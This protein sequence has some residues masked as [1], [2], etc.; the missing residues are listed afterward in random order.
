MAE[1]TSKKKSYPEQAVNVEGDSEEALEI[2]E[3][4]LKLLDELHDMHR[5]IMF[6]LFDLTAAGVNEA[7]STSDVKHMRRLKDEIGFHCRMILLNMFRDMG[8]AKL[9]VGDF[10]DEYGVYVN[11]DIVISESNGDSIGYSFGEALGRHYLGQRDSLV[12]GIM[13]FAEYAFG[14]TSES[15]RTE[16][17]GVIEIK[18]V[19]SAR[20]LY[21]AS[22]AKAIIEDQIRSFLIKLEAN[23]VVNK[24][25]NLNPMVRLNHV[26]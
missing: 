6:K 8:E 24:D 20:A 15:I 2:E 14:G 7:P 9:I 4:L 25:G 12:K 19:L 17:D 1:R 18:S 10:D 5:V 21:F 23:Y 16:E 13:E 26:G 22:R 11:P 3:G